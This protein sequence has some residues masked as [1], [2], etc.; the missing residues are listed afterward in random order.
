M[1]RWRE[2]AFS[3]LGYLWI[4][5]VALVAIACVWLFIMQSNREFFMT[6]F[7]GRRDRKQFEEEIAGLAAQEEE[8]SEKFK[9][10]HT[11]SWPIYPGM[12]DPFEFDRLDPSRIPQS[13]RTSWQPE[14]LVGLLGNSSDPWVGGA[15]KGG[16]EGWPQVSFSAD[17]R[18]IA[19]V[20]MGGVFLPGGGVFLL[21]SGKLAEL[22]RTPRTDQMFSTNSIAFS[23]TGQFLA[24]CG[25]IH[26]GEK[27]TRGWLG[28]WRIEKE[29]LG[30]RTVVFLPYDVG[31]LAFSPNGRFLAVG[32]SRR[33]DWEK[34]RPLELWEVEE[35]ELRPFWTFS[36]PL[37]F[38]TIAFSPDSRI[39]VAAGDATIHLYHL[40]AESP[41]EW[42]G[43]WLGLLKIAGM[44]AAP[45][46]VIGLWLRSRFA[47]RRWTFLSRWAQPLWVALLL[48]VLLSLAGAGV[49][50]WQGP[51]IDRIHQT[52]STPG[53]IGALAFS[54]DGALLACGGEAR[55]ESLEEEWKGKWQLALMIGGILAAFALA[56]G[57]WRRSRLAPS[58]ETR[59]GEAVERLAPVS[60]I[61]ALL[62]LASG[63]WLWW[64]GPTVDLK[65]TG[66]SILSRWTVQG[67]RLEGRTD[68]E[69]LLPL[70]RAAFSPDGRT[71]VSIHGYDP[72]REQPADEPL[73]RFWSVGEKLEERSSLRI[74][75]SQ[76]A[77]VCFSP[78]GK[79][80]VG[81][82]EEFYSRPRPKGLGTEGRRLRL[83]NL[84]GPAP[85][86]ITGEKTWVDRP[87]K[88]ASGPL[89]TT[90]RK[91]RPAALDLWRMSNG[92][93][94][95]S[96]KIPI[97]ATP[98][99]PHPM[100]RF[101]D[102][103]T[104]IFLERRR[105]AW[106]AVEGIP[107]EDDKTHDHHWT[108]LRMYDLS[109]G[110]PRS[111][112]KLQWLFKI[113]KEQ[114][115]QADT[116]FWSMAADKQSLAC[117]WRDR[118]EVMVCDLSGPLRQ[119]G[120]LRGHGAEVSAV[121]LST[122]GA[123]AA[124]GTRGK[125]VHL[126]NLKTAKPRR[127]PALGA[128]AAVAWL[129]FLPDGKRLVAVG[130]D[131]K[132]TLWDL[133]GPAPRVVFTGKSIKDVAAD[134][135]LA[136]YPPMPPP[137][138]L[139]ES[140]NEARMEWLHAFFPPSCTL[141]AEWTEAG[142]VTIHRNANGQ[143]T[144]L[145]EWTQPRAPDSLEPTL[146]GKHLIVANGPDTVLIVRLDPRAADSRLLDSCNAL[147]ERNPRDVASLVQRAA[148]H[149]RHGDWSLGLADA[150][151][152]VRYDPTNIEGWWLCG[153]VH[154]RRQDYAQAI[155]DFTRVLHLRPR[156]ALARYQRGLA[157]L[158]RE[159]FAAARQDLT[160]A[161]TI[162]PSLAR[163]APAP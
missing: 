39:L 99:F 50:W 132:V 46:L 129:E 75:N 28:L 74:K 63:G 110:K 81:Y 94:D 18:M 54:P 162:D 156:H 2:V 91:V 89:L 31:R 58:L 34:E 61:L 3:C 32:G 116:S 145:A 49:L 101:R 88:Q 36:E 29:R 136:L 123:W 37:R 158:E 124:V 98:W 16:W 14:G 139:G 120:E 72:E 155:A 30:E 151:A 100:I 86:E 144:K 111:L 137:L 140:R 6:F 126:W 19:G 22:D 82:C 134:R 57:L 117:W 24:A 60:V 163:H 15:G 105:F 80:L 47:P 153:C 113:E 77:E 114:F 90:M 40:D 128:S 148:F 33:K 142:R 135:G 115:D 35:G 92:R 55:R 109:T 157:R 97:K 78:N 85:R 141:E 64:C 8:L 106:W 44:L 133:A 45:A 122:K 52:V 146:D 154:V 127:L 53:F 131:R 71:L 9:K 150:K 56:L 160:Q 68:A 27:T 143:R 66:R 118:D 149:L 41:E 43:K 13:E 38:G 12:A 138:E 23:P 69:I 96:M 104:L 17:G 102:E 70:N 62:V 108:A 93:L 67:G 4:A 73:L 25:S 119:I 130:E 10:T 159:E 125:K 11:R 95:H 20:S 121:A 112:G 147:I 84:E 26:L 1:S 79:H 152:A 87:G 7:E 83:W 103:R 59:L 76:V 107:L 65:D 21:D 42:E 161:L 51:G 48:L 5:V